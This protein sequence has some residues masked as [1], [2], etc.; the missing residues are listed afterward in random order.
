MCY[1]SNILNY[2]I[3]HDIDYTPNKYER[4]ILF[5][6]YEMS[7]QSSIRSA[8]H[9]AFILDSN[10]DIKCVYLN[11]KVAYK[12]KSEHAESG[13]IKKFQKEYGDCLADG[14]RL[15]VVK[16]TM[17]GVGNSRPCYE[18]FESIRNAGI[19]EVVYSNGRDGKGRDLYKK[20]YINQ[21]TIPQIPPQ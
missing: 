5:L 21:D 1:I 2:K 12:I 17:L 4:N 9:A 15:F 10:D 3:P 11:Q 8:R 16:G 18:C 20:M 6:A 19:K 14:Y 7:F 13:V